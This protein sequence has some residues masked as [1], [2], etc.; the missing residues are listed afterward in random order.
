MFKIIKVTGLSLSP[1]FLPDDY[2]LLWRAP[3]QFKK[4]APGDFIV[5]DHNE[6]GLLIKEVVRNTTTEEFI[7][8]KGIHPDSLSTQR[9][10]K[11]PY[12]NIVGKV[13]RRIHLRF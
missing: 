13:F 8:A 2:V 4:L 11:I 7:E 6:Y 5:F 10:G 12:K 1:F 9:M 3:R